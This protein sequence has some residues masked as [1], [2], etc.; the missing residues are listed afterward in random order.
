MQIQYAAGDA[1]VAIEIFTRLVHDKLTPP[2]SERDVRQ[3]ALSICQGIVD[4]PYSHKSAGVKVS[5]RAYPAA[6]Q[7]AGC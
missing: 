7:Y 3:K 5:S 6:P 1:L 2:H 4:V